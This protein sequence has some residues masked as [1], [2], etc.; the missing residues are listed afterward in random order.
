MIR[1]TSPRP[2][3]EADPPEQFR[4]KRLSF[5]FTYRPSR[6]CLL[7]CR[8]HPAV[9]KSCSFTRP[10]GRGETLARRSLERKA[11]QRADP[12]WREAVIYQVYPRSFMDASGDGVGDLVSITEKLDYLSWLGVDAIWLS[13][14]YH[15]PMADRQNGC[16]NGVCGVVCVS[17]AVG[18]CGRRGCGRRGRADGRPG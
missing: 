9:G 15:S 7:P 16:W 18:C 14:I 2:R 10:E 13:P 1:E 8:R 5:R 17:C 4:S 6:C 11:G 3:C 12:W